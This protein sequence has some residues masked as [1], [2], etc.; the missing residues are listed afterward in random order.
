MDWWWA[1]FL[2]G[3]VAGAVATIGVLR[4]ILRDWRGG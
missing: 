4:Y 2:A 3:A 1:W